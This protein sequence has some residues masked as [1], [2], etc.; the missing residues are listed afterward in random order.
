LQRGHGRSNSAGP[1]TATYRSRLDRI[2]SI[3][4][5]EERAV[6]ALTSSMPI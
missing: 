5:G 1:A 3:T 6:C 4:A 2:A